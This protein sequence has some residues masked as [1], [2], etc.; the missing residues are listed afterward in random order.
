MLRV[1]TEQELLKGLNEE[2]VHAD[3]LAEPTN[4]EW[5]M[6]SDT[7]RHGNPLAAPLERLRGSVKRYDQPIEPLPDWDEWFDGEGV[8]EDFMANREQPNNQKR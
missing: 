2:N 6:G 5:G 8:S 7:S 4:K 3:E 1:P